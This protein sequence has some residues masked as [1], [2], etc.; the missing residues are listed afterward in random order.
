MNEMYRLL[1]IVALVVAVVLGLVIIKLWPPNKRQSFSQHV[2]SRKVTYWLFAPIFTVVTVMYYA[3]LWKWV[4]PL[5]GMGAAYYDVLLVAFVLQLIVAW[6]PAKS[7]WPMRVHGIAAYG[8]AILMVALVVIIALTASSVLPVGYIVA[9][10]VFGLAGIALVPIY[11]YI[12]AARRQ[13][14]LVQIG[15]FVAFWVL[16][17]AIAYS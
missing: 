13:F 8:V 16:I 15:Y 5:V 11:A 10:Y 7:V 14:L 12:P 2:A 1:G 3:F 17:M 6:V 4:G 9:C